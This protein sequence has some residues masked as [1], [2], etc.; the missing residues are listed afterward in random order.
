MLKIIFLKKYIFSIIFQIKF[1]L[2]TNRYYIYE[3]QSIPNFQ[4]NMRIAQSPG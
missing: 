1:T 2:K 4:L 3:Q